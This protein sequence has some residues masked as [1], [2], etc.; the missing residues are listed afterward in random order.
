MRVEVRPFND[1]GRPLPKAQFKKQPYCMGKLRIFDD[2][3]HYL[4]RPVRR[5]TLTHPTD[6]LNTSLMPDLIDVEVLW[7]DDTTMRL[8]GMEHIE[9][10]FYGQTWDIKVLKCSE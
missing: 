5:A 1:R 6:G 3:M 4:D 8:R 2:R 7:L 9:G 10:A